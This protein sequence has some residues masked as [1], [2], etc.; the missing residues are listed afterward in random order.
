MPRASKK[1]GK[2]V[3]PGTNHAGQAAK[4]DAAREKRA[5]D[6]EKQELLDAA[7]ALAPDEEIMAESEEVSPQPMYTPVQSEMEARWC[8]GVFVRCVGRG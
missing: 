3:K 4:R 1:H 5:R 7:A 6:A 8:A 2:Y